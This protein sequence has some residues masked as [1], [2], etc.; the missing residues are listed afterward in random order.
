M[1]YKPGPLGAHRQEIA[2]KLKQLP[3][4]TGDVF[5]RT[6]KESFFGLPF[7][8]LVAR[9]TKSKWSH[10]SMAL[11][12]DDI[13]LVEVGSEDTLQLRVI[14]WLELCYRPEFAVYRPLGVFP[15]AEKIIRAFLE[16]DPAYNYDFAARSKTYYCTQSAVAM[17]TK[18]GVKGSFDPRKPKDVLPAWAYYLIFNPINSMVRLLSGGRVGF[19]KDTD[20]YFAGNALHGM[21]SNPFLLQ[22]YPNNV[23]S[24]LMRTAAFALSCD[25][26]ED[27]DAPQ[28]APRQ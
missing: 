22:V 20:F 6:G 5:F 11:V 7:S 26:F 18:F 19:P 28:E 2:A 9:A 14:D 25:P 15:A 16:E 24:T 27:P 8:P 10:A 3:V 12:T 17:M 21:L 23:Y 13:Y 1:T 4:K